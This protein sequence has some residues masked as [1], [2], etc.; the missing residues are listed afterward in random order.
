MRNVKG[1]VPS[2]KALRNGV[3][4]IRQAGNR[5]V[6]QTAYANCGRKRALADVQEH[7]IVAFV[8]RWRAKRFCTCEYI[9]KEFKLDVTPRTVANVLNRH[10]YYWR[11]VPK[12]TLPPRAE[13]LGQAEGIRREAHFS[14]RRLVE[15]AHESHY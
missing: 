3:E 2:F 6:P 1:G 5:G 8:K 7:P 14:Q 15:T 4:R 12:V 13:A 9:A 11:S 10:G